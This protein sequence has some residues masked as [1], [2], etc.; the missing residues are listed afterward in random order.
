MAEALRGFAVYD[1]GAKTWFVFNGVHWAECNQDQIDSVLIGLLYQG[2]ALTGFT[3]SYK[4]NVRGLMAGA[5]FLPMPKPAKGSLPFSNGVLN[6]HTKVLYPATP[7]IALTWCLPYDYDPVADC[8]T[9]KAWLL[10]AV[11]GDAET[12]EFLRAWMAALLHGRADLQKF[13]HLFG[14]GGTGKGVLSD[15]CLH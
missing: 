8:P 5:G 10:Q 2:A 3:L 9:I 12:V 15:W 11:D 14:S 7:E 13:L 6:I 1:D 4:N